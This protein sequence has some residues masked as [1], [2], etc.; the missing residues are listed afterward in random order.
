MSLFLGKELAGFKM[1]PSIILDHADLNQLSNTFTEQITQW[2]VTAFYFFICLRSHIHAVN[3]NEY[4]LLVP[5][6][7]LIVIKLV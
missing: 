4:M 6:H 7:R 2:K 3:R 1:T 5:Y